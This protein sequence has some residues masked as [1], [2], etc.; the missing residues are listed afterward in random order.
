[1]TVSPATLRQLADDIQGEVVP[2]GWSNILQAL[3]Q[4]A[5]EIERLQERMRANETEKWID[6]HA[7]AVKERDEARH[8]VTTQAK[9][10]RDALDQWERVCAELAAEHRKHEEAREELAKLREDLEWQGAC[11]KALSEWQTNAVARLQLAEAVCEMA[12]YQGVYKD[13]PA[14]YEVLAAWRAGATSPS[15]R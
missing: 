5:D 3:R 12:D 7:T 13:C 10:A 15:P 4:A 2:V 1:M 9:L 6:L 8:E 11:T 14:L